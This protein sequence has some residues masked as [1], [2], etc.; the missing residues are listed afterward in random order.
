MAKDIFKFEVVIPP[1]ITGMIRR[2]T[3]TNQRKMMKTMGRDL[4][5][6]FARFFYAASRT[7]HKTA[8]KY[9]VN[10]TGILEFNDGFPARSRGGG[11]ITARESGN[12][13][14]LTVSGVPF[15]SRAYHPLFITPKKASC[16]T[17]PISRESVHK[18]AADLRKAGWVL[19]AG[20]RRNGHGKGILFGKKGS[21]IVALYAL[22]KNATIPQDKGLMP[23][24]AE[25]G[26]WAASS[27]KK[28]LGL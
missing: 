16:L 26:T 27:A 5:T 24:E 15:L 8:K 13:V 3:A 18:R 14:T 21:S 12:V 6:S 17:I 19:F 25:V 11:E 28:F 7:R 20:N 10:P 1:S 2:L 22:V 4:T 23:T 9:G